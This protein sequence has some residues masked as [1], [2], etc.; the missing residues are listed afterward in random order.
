[1]AADGW[2][3][4]RVEDSEDVDAL[5]AALSAAR[6]EDERPSFISIRSHIAY[7]APHAVDTA[8][9]HGAALGEDEVRAPRR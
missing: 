9:S 8:K 1:M 4:Q 3:V 2:H 5:E 6:E 7:P